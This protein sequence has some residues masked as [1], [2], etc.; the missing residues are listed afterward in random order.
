MFHYLNGMLCATKT[1]FILKIF[2]IPGM[3][4]CFNLQIQQTTNWYFF[5]Y[6]F[7][8][9][10][11]LW[12]SLD[13]SLTI[14][15]ILCSLFDGKQIK[16]WKK[17]KKKSNCRLL[18]FLPSIYKLFHFINPC[19]VPDAFSSNNYQKKVAHMRTEQTQTTVLSAFFGDFFIRHFI[20]NEKNDLSLTISC[21]KQFIFNIFRKMLFMTKTGCAQFLY[22]YI[23]FLFIFFSVILSHC[24][25]IAILWKFYKF[26]KLA[27]KL[28]TILFFF[29]LHFYYWKNENENI[30]FLNTND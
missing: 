8:S 18:K 4:W 11:R 30:R 17:K 15:D 25:S 14:F 19:N 27:F 24:Y 20:L 13:F 1:S 26:W 7:F 23:F 28:P 12:H 9:E 22:I 3:R 10:N 16:I 6:L 5:L 2:T 21:Q 29:F